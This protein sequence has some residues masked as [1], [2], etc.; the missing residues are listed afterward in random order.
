M[1]CVHT[2]DVLIRKTIL[3][4]EEAGCP[5]CEAVL[6]TAEHLIFGCPFTV[7]FWRCLDVSPDD[8]SVRALHLFNVDGAVG[9]A[10]WDAFVLLCCW[11]LWKRR[12]TVVFRDGSLSLSTTLEACRDDAVL[13]RARMEVENR[14][15]IDAWLEVLIFLCKSYNSLWRKYQQGA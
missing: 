7:Q 9:D 3:K 2:R 12:N 4:A 6:E 10:S 1:S 11:R 14:T 13:W 15:H 5:C 8:A